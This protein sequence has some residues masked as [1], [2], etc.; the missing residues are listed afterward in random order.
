M[1]AITHMGGKNMVDA[2][3]QVKTSPRRVNSPTYLKPQR[4]HSTHAQQLAPSSQSSQCKDRKS[5]LL[6]WGRIDQTCVS[7][8]SC[9]CRPVFQQEV[10]RCAI[11]SSFWRVE[12]VQEKSVEVSKQWVKTGRLSATCCSSACPC[13]ELRKSLVDTKLTWEMCYLPLGFPKFPPVHCHVTGTFWLFSTANNSP[14]RVA[15]FS[16]RALAP[17]HP[18][19]ARPLAQ[20]C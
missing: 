10:R 3:G 4:R 1:E 5:S 12:L 19:Q 9:G 2:D 14:A 11:R 15:V 18:S 8:T 17:L 20:V 6:P 16:T 13:C 7:S